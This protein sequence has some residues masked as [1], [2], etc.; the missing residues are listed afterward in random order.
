MTASDGTGS[1]PGDPG[2]SGEAELHIASS[3]WLQDTKEPR[4]GDSEPIRITVL[5]AQFIAAIARAACDGHLAYVDT[6]RLVSMFLNA[7]VIEHQNDPSV[8]M[9][10]TSADIWT[11]IDKLPWPRGGKPQGQ[12]DV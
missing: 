7:R 5:E 1:S 2:L 3:D 4:P 10:R 9:S 6:L 12:P 8:L 11:E